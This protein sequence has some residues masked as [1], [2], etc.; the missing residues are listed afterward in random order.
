M[1][2]GPGW[3]SRSSRGSF[4]R[5]GA[6]SGWSRP[7]D[8]GRPSA[9]LRGRWERRQLA[10]VAHVVLDDDGCLHVRD[11]LLHALDRGDRRGAVEVEVR[12]AAAVVILAEV[13]Q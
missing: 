12:H 3:G 9:L 7:K 8:R 10:D 4:R 5:A 1:W 13:D 11:D 2:R 6:G